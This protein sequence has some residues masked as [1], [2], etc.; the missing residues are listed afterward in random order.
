MVEKM[1]A[2][3]LIIITIVVCASVPAI[4]IYVTATPHMVAGLSSVESMD[5][6]LAIRN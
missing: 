5:Y 6:L 3:W 1:T 4:L 2:V